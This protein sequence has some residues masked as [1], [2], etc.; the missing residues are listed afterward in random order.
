VILYWFTE[1]GSN[2]NTNLSNYDNKKTLI[3][4]CITHKEEI[5]LNELEKDINQYLPP[6]GQ[7]SI[8]TTSTD[9]SSIFH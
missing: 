9:Q 5:V 2:L 8:Y 7:K 6:M 4:L 3:N 1:K